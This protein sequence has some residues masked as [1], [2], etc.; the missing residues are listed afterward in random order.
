MQKKQTQHCSKKR[1]KNKE[2]KR[3]RSHK[4]IKS[5]RSFCIGDRTNACQMY[6]KRNV[7]E[8]CWKMAIFPFAHFIQDPSQM[9]TTIKWKY[10]RA[11]YSRRKKNERRNCSL[12]LTYD[13]EAMIFPSA[14]SPFYAQIVAVKIYEE[15]WWSRESTCNFLQ[16]TVCG[17]LSNASWNCLMTSKRSANKTRKT[18]H[19]RVTCSLQRPYNGNAAKAF[20]TH[21][22]SQAQSAAGITITE[23][24]SDRGVWTEI[25]CGV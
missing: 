10:A 18:V 4:K 20:T 16:R 5:I 7:A 21:L 11:F 15:Q 13:D 14:H 12:K 8:P 22:L 24:D 6:L 17:Q 19:A 2:R 1:R 25:V 3:K 23:F 9:I